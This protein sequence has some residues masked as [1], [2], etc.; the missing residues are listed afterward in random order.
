MAKPKYQ[1][2]AALLHNKETK[3]TQKSKK[4]QAV[5]VSFN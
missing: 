3:L 1:A 5:Q 2:V 4:P